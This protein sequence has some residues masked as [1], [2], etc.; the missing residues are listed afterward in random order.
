MNQRATRKTAT[1]AATSRQ[2]GMRARPLNE[3]QSV[4]Y[5][6]QRD[7]PAGMTYRWIAE[8]VLQNPT[9]NNVTRQLRAGWRPVP[10]DRHPE[11][12]P[13]VIPGLTEADPLIRNGGLLLCERPTHDIE[14]DVSRLEDA[15]RDALNRASFAADQVDG[16]PR[17]DDSSP[18]QIEQVTARGDFKE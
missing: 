9:P 4:L 8:T 18:V 16:V 1:R 5:I 11:W 2:A 15:T 7:I 3:M 12:Q 10:S 17:F 6:D 14:Q 13:P